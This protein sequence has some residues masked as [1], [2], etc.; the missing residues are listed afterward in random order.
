MEI[1]SSAYGGSIL[2]SNGVIDSSGFDYGLYL[3]SE[4]AGKH[5]A[6]QVYSESQTVPN[7]I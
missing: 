2:G 3:S 6:K 1:Q 7:Y 4:C 5:Q